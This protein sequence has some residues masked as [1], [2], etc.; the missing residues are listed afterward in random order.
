MTQFSLS[1]VFA[2]IMTF[3]LSNFIL[4]ICLKN[5]AV[6]ENIFSKVYV[7]LII[8]IFITSFFAPYYIF[9]NYKNPLISHADQLQIKATNPIISAINDSHLSDGKREAARVLALEALRQGTVLSVAISKIPKLKMV[10]QGALNLLNISPRYQENVSKAEKNLR[11]IRIRKDKCLDVYLNKVVELGRYKPEYFSFAMDSIRN[12]D[13]TPR[14]RIVIDLL[15]THVHSIRSNSQ[16][17][18]ERWLS[19]FT[20]YFNDYVD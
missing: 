5:I 4:P 15:N 16:P 18:P 11:N 14:E 7:I 12:G 10:H 19:E 2:V 6:P 8:C 13:L 20:Q 9:S 3:C 17:N 1:L